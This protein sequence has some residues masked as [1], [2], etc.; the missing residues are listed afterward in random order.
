MN[1]LKSVI[2]S[3]MLLLCFEYSP[4]QH[5]LSI[6]NVK[7]DIYNFGFYLSEV[8]NATGT[9]FKV[10]SVQKSVVYN[11]IS[12][13]LSEDVAIEVS[14]FLH[15]NMN[16]K[17]DGK[18]LIVRVNQIDI[19]EYYNGYTETAKAEVDLSFIYKENDTYVNKFSSHS[20]QSF[21]AVV[22]V[23]KHQPELI[24]EALAE[25]FDLFYEADCENRLLN[26]TIPEVEL[27][28][29]PAYD[30][31][32]MNTLNAIDRSEKGLYNSFKQFKDNTPDTSRQFIIDQNIKLNTES[33]MKV[34]NAEIFDATTNKEIDKIWGFSDGRISYYRLGNKYLPLEK[35]AISYYIEMKVYDDDKLSKA[36]V[37]AGLIGTSIAMATTSKSKVRLNIISGDFVPEDLVQNEFPMVHK[38]L[39]RIIFYGSVFN[40]ANKPMDLIINEEVICQLGKSTWFEKHVYPNTTTEVVIRTQN[41]VESN[42]TLETGQCQTSVILCIDKKKK[43]PVIDITIGDKKQEI[44][45]KLTKENRI[46]PKK[47]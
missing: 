32:E 39:S 23:T 19:S 22:G 2:I 12:A 5:I 17:L 46:R 30:L 20:V 6:K 10:G 8:T 42:I 13:F 43:P 34:K 11:K 25:C 29:K 16:D 37:W 27:T 47:K 9:S 14:S 36:G 45:T 38:C 28:Q 44:R 15:N 3:F 24:G 33:S 26:D 4:A 21:T 31:L 35:D 1:R 7:A 41:G 40:P 18:A